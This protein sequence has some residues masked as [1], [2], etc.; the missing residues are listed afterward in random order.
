MT[1]SV[2]V[3]SRAWWLALAALVLVAGCAGDEAEPPTSPTTDGRDIT[4]SSAGAEIT[5]RDLPHGE[6]RVVQRVVDGDTLV[7]DGGERVRL[8]GID[9]PETKDPRRPVECFGREAAGFAESLLAS[10]TEVRLVFDVEEVDRYDRTL[11]Y[12]YRLRDGLFVNLELLEEGY[13]QVFT[14]PP[15]VEHADDFR[16]AARRVREQ[17]RGLWAAC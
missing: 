1:G 14:V 13:A 10:G 8:I 5:R 2:G 16:A 6:D 9:T 4:T 17:Q 3:N 7:V 12:V 15:N 11:A